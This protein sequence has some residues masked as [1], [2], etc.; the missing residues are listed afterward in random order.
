VIAMLDIDLKSLLIAI[1][2]PRVVGLMCMSLSEFEVLLQAKGNADL[3]AKQLPE[4]QQTLNTSEEPV[5]KTLWFL[6]RK[7]QKVWVQEHDLDAGYELR[8]I[9][10]VG[11]NHRSVAV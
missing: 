4:C 11:G 9:E 3:Y 8:L 2:F 6:L 7:Q 10:F 5:I 1:S